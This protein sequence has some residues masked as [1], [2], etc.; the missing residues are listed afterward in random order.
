MKTHSSDRRASLHTRIQ[1]VCTEC[2]SITTAHCPPSGTMGCYQP[3]PGSAP[4]NASLP[5]SSVCVCV[6]TPHKQC[7]IACLY[8]SSPL[9]FC[10]SH[11]PVSHVICCCQI[12]RA[13]L[14]LLTRADTHTHTP[15]L[16][17]TQTHTLTE[18]SCLSAALF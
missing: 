5:V 16:T 2:G 7:F 9:T 6:C 4:Y 10:L 18:P 1:P 14:S 15:I 12:Y 17:Q 3:E 11:Y 13:D 8:L